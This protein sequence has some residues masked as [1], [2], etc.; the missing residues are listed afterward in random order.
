MWSF[1]QIYQDQI[2]PVFRFVLRL[3]G[4][5]EVAEDITSETFLTLYRHRDRVAEERLPAWLFTIAKNRAR[6]YWRRTLTERRLAEQWAETEMT[7]VAEPG[8]VA[9]LIES[10]A[11]K[12]V[13]RLCLFLRYV[14]GMSRAEIAAYT[15]LSEV[16]IKGHLQ[17]ALQLLRKELAERDAAGPAVEP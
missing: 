8:F 4:N 15:A 16:Q 2:E 6:D 17:D 13:H 9:N 3:V 5:R 12:P 1:E 10:K 11:L 14:H 7:T